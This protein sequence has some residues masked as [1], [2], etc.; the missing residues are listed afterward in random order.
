MPKTFMLSPK[1]KSGIFVKARSRA[2]LIKRLG[3]LVLIVS[4]KE[5]PNIRR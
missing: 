4:I 3:N 2:S 1:G 5:M